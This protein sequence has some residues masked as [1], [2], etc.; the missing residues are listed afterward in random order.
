MNVNLLLDS[1]SDRTLGDYSHM[2]YYLVSRVVSLAVGIS[3]L[4][5]KASVILCLEEG[6]GL[7][8]VRPPPLD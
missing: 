5:I 2:W 7:K 6:R 8:A 4:G 1:V 3:L